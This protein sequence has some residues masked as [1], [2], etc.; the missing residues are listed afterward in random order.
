MELYHPP[1]R[2]SIEAFEYDLSGTPSFF[3]PGKSKVIGSM[4]TVVRKAH[5]YALSLGETPETF[6]WKYIDENHAERWYNTPQGKR[7]KIRILR[8]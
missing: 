3:A 4:K 7:F 2:S 5:R 8:S 6:R 1:Y